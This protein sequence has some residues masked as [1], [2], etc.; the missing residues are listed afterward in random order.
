[1]PSPTET[2]TAPPAESPEERRE[3]MRELGRRGAE[4]RWRGKAKK[5]AAGDG[6]AEAASGGGSEALSALLAVI[7]SHDAPHA[8]VVAAAR[9]LLDQEAGAS[10][11]T[12]HSVAQVQALSTAD[13]HSLV[14]RLDASQGQ[15]GDPSSTST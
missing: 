12:P 7:R 1:M 9:A 3:R 5:D 10:T 2:T 8:A 13:L 11:V 15:W 6:G 4:A 14:A